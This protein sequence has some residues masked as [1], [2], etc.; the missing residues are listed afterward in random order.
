VS[1]RRFRSP[2]PSDPAAADPTALPPEEL[3]GRFIA[4]ARSPRAGALLWALR[5]RIATGR[6]DVREVVG[7]VQAMRDLGTLADDAAFY[8]LAILTE[9]A[10]I[11][12]MDDDARL[13]AL[14]DRME[15]IE[16][17]AGLGE[18][19]A[20]LIDEAPA[21]WKAASDEWS[22][23]FDGLWAALLRELGEREM[24]WARLHDESAFEARTMDG[25]EELIG[26]IEPE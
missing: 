6:D 21:E 23:V 1:R 11:S 17:A 12:R 10:M 20:F 13:T 3:L 5:T 14:R 4:G 25:R 24:A 9:E 2:R 7:Y 18:D 26:P 19:E 16:R 15:A 8:L 22:A